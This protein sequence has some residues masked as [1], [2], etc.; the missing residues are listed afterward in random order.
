MKG[1][2]QEKE[3]NTV[4]INGMQVVGEFHQNDCQARASCQ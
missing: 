1:K 2:M 3:E 4:K